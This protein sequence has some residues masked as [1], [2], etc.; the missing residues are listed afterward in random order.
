MRI[1]FICHRLPFPPNRG[2]KIR[3]FN[4]IRHL[5][6]SHEVVV[7][8]LAESETEL[9]EGVGLSEYC[10][11]VLAD[12]LPRSVRWAQALNALRMRKPSSVA[13]FWSSRLFQR[14]QAE[15]NFDLIWVHCAFVAQYV[16]NI[17]NAIKV[18][19]FGDIDSAKWL[20][21]SHWRAWPLSTGYRLEA[22]KLRRYEAE[23]TSQFDHYTVTARGELEE[24]RKL[25]SMAPCTLIPNGVE[26][27]F[28]RPVSHC[29]HDSPLIIF[30][31]RMDYFP[32]V[33]GVSYF[34][35]KTFPIIQKRVSN[36][37]LRIIGSNPVKSIRDMARIPGITV[38]GHVA[39]VRPYMSNGS[40][41][42]APLRIARGTQNKILESMA[43]GIPVV[44]TTQAAKGVQAVPGR[45]LLVADNPEAFA[46]EVVKLLINEDL[47]KSLSVAAHQQIKSVHAWPVSMQILDGVFARLQ[48]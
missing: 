27:A 15:G 20:D 41:A 40:V 37:Q 4:M 5:S 10:A 35:R 25:S 45:H 47:R 28:F 12:V 42:I 21:Y 36:I 46:N 39:D 26:T 9:R 23:L 22:E 2:G 44:A 7:A 48:V 33:D 30:V 17:K 6:K 19:D 29:S 13:Y 31:G 24:L 3:P 38:T 14:I 32:N 43:M 11:E 18:L 8:S 1:L 34:V 16:V